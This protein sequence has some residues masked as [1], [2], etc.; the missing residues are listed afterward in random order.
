MADQTT[1]EK[2]L[3]ILTEINNRLTTIEQ[4]IATLKG[5]TETSTGDVEFG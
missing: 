4:D 3:V 2:I 1:G 5:T